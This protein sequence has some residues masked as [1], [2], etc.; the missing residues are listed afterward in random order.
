M[1]NIELYAVKYGTSIFSTRYI[2]YN[3]NSNK[4]VGFAWLFY[5][6]KADKKIILIDTG[7]DDAVLQ[8]QFGVNWQ[9]PIVI[10]GK[11]LGITPD[12]IT[13]VVIT[14]NHFDHIGL[15]YEFN[16]ADIH[17]NKADYDDYIKKSKDGKIRNFLST[18]D[19]I[20]TF[21][22]IYALGKYVTVKLIGGHTRGSSVV[23]MNFRGEK[24]MITGDECYLN[25]NFIKQIPVGTYFDIS[26]NRSF[27]ESLKDTEMKILTMHE[28]TI[29]AKNKNIKLIFRS[30]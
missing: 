6:L 15:V 19:R 2:F 26:K 22:D 10:L 25:D 23:I 29:V 11:D 13:D 14:H 4:N 18:Y 20:I 7:F 12:Q 5:L 27:I 1:N 17:I 9:N 8:K 30:K 28:P 16:K 3:D 24:F 21:D